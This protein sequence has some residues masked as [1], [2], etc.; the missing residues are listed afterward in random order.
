MF[1][2]WIKD[3]QYIFASQAKQVFYVPDL[4]LG[5]HWYVVESSPPRKLFDVPVHEVYQE[6]KAHSSVILNYNVEPS[7]LTRGTILLEL[8][9][10]STVRSSQKRHGID[11]YSNDDEEI[12]PTNLEFSE[13][14]ESLQE[15]YSDSGSS[16]LI[17]F[18]SFAE[19]NTS[20]VSESSS[21]DLK[22]WKYIKAVSK[23]WAQ[24]DLK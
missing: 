7:L 8:V 16:A 13:N 4:K 5:K 9:D 2:K 17:S 20:S 12:D 21:S 23:V 24:R 6:H 14:G 18:G 15:E 1:R 11:E 10:A 22:Q 19:H 3:Q